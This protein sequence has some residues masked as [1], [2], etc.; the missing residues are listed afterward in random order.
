ME[1]IILARHGE[2]EFSCRGAVNGDPTVACDLT[3]EGVE[4]ARALG[5]ALAG[6]P[7]DLCITSEFLRTRRTADIALECREDVAREVDPELNDIRLGR[8]EGGRLEDFRWWLRSAGPSGIPEGGGES[9]VQALDRYCGAF[10]RIATR[11]ERSILVVTHGV[12]VTVVPLAA[13]DLDPPLTLE[14]AQAIYAT[15]AFLSAGELDRAL[16]L[17]EDWTRRTAAAP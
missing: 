10:R 14:R 17:L 15:A 11:P 5:R 4:Q 2:S 7:I 6:E 9:R 12:P 16:S 8:F 1:R 3:E 13:R